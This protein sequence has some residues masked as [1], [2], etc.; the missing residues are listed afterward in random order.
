MNI[1]EM[2]ENKKLHP[3]WNGSI[4]NSMVIYETICKFLGATYSMAYFMVE[5]LTRFTGHAL[6]VVCTVQLI[7]ENQLQA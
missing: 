4:P 5:H 2:R 3:R 6:K 7:L 1:Y